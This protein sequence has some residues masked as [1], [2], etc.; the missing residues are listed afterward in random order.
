MPHADIARNIIFCEFI[1]LAVLG[2]FGLAAR[3]E[4]RSAQSF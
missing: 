2:F 1:S 4:G 3:S